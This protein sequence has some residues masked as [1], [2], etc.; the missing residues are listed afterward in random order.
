MGLFDLITGRDTVQEDIARA[1]ANNASLKSG[2]SNLLDGFVRQQ[3]TKRAHG[4]LIF[5]PTIPMFHKNMIGFGDTPSSYACGGN[6]IRA[7]DRLRDGGLVYEKGHPVGRKLKMEYV[8]KDVDSVPA[9]LSPGEFVLTKKMLGRV[10]KVFKK[11]KEKLIK[12]M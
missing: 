1:K 8:V 5:N 12:G 11:N 10:K 4:G 3:L 6:V 2:L 7:S 9:I